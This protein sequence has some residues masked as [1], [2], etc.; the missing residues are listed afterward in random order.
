VGNK[1]NFRNKRQK[2]GRKEKRDKMKYKQER[3]EKVIVLLVKFT[4][5]IR[6]ISLHKD[7]FVSK[8]YSRTR[9]KSLGSVGFCILRFFSFLKNF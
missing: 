5:S 2:E 9:S 8:K 6:K 4:K 7:I 1:V 3:E